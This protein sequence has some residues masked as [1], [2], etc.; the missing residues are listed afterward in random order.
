[1]PNPTPR[2]LRAI[3]AQVN[4]RASLSATTTRQA[5]LANAHLRVSYAVSLALDAERGAKGILRSIAN[6]LVVDRRE[7]FDVDALALNGQY[8]LP[9][10]AVVDVLYTDSQSPYLHAVRYTHPDTKVTGRLWIT[11][12]GIKAEEGAASIQVSVVLATQDIASSALP[13]VAPTRPRVVGRL[14]SANA[15]LPGTAGLEAHSLNLQNVEAFL[16]HLRDARRTTPLVV[17]SMVNGS[18]PLVDVQRLRVQGCGIAD[19]YVIDGNVDTHALADRAGREVIPWGGGVRILYPTS[20]GP[21]ADQVPVQTI[22]PVEL[23]DW[24][25]QGDDPT[26]RLF[27]IVATRTARTNASRHLTIEAVREEQIRRRVAKER[28]RHDALASRAAFSLAQA[29]V[30]DL[31]ASIKDLQADIA[32]YEAILQEHDQE[33]AK[34]NT[35]LDQLEFERDELREQL[36]TANNKARSLEGSISQLRDRPLHASPMLDDDTRGSLIAMMNGTGTIVDTLRAVVHLYGNRLVV[37]DSAWKSAKDAIGFRKAQKAFDL[38]RRLGSDYWESLATGKPDSQA[39]EAFTKNEFASDESDTVANN[40]L[41]RKRR[42]FIYK[43]Q[44]I[45]MLPHLKIG[46]KPSE[47]ETLRIHF[48]WDAEARVIVIGHCGAHIDFD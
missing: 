46:T 23:D 24:R 6:W 44:N 15:P 25:V 47:Y 9:S 14:L 12:I 3:A 17:I 8:T 33:I 4:S 37:L 21:Y 29:E 22:R 48:F 45:E 41:A 35:E 2:P 20:S 18:G 42:T 43:G 13:P 10:G 26:R 7:T 38:L 39:K 5:P 28:N 30:A 11:E 27:E 19:F 34:K 31:T 36:S 40:K 32:D 1:M 16:T